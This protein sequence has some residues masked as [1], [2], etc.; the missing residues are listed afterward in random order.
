TSTP[1]AS[2]RKPQKMPP[3]TGRIQG[4]RNVARTGRVDPYRPHGQKARQN[5][6]HSPSVQSP[7]IAVTN[8]SRD[9]ADF[10]PQAFFAHA[11]GRLAA[12]VEREANDDYGL[13]PGMPAHA[14][15]RDAAV[16]IPVLDRSPL[17]MLFTLRTPRLSSHAGQVSF[18]GGKID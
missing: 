1:V 2:A 7:G 4:C 15:Y 5:H 6:V 11:A 3:I 9:S 10:A 17:T 12:P 18:P 16:L 14:T 13:N 8:D